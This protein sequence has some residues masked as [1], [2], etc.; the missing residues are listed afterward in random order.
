MRLV[1]FVFLVAVLAGAMP[2]AAREPV[3]PR[4]P[5]WEQSQLME[6]NQAV[7]TI[8][9]FGYCAIRVRPAPSEAMVASLPYS[10]EEQA[11]E[12]AL[13]EGA[14]HPCLYQTERMTLRSRPVVRGILA[15]FMY[16]RAVPGPRHYQPRPFN[17]RFDPV[18]AR[19]RGQPN[20]ALGRFVATCAVHRDPN[21][22]HLM[23]RF[24]HYS[25][26]ETRELRALRPTMLACLPEGRSLNVSRLV[27]RALL[28]EA[29][30]HFWQEDPSAGVA[31]R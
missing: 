27:I 31:P 19:W 3:D 17:E 16:N 8:R 28:A 21:P 20:E 5:T 30:Y 22:V 10:A 12:D 23:V 18:N 24:N 13:T 25:P 1:R 14:D 2:A 26:G 7:R 6:G 11:A 9:A 4:L 29:L 15:E